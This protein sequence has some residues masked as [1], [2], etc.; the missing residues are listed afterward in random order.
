MNTDKAYNDDLGKLIEETA[1][2]WTVIV[3]NDTECG[4]MVFEVV[5]IHDAEEV[6]RTFEAF[7][8]HKYTYSLNREE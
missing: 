6:I 2:K 8:K 7:G 4:E 1:D 5:D 3:H